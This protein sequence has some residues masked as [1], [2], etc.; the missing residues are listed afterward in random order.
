MRR[1]AVQFGL[2]LALAVLFVVFSFLERDCDPLML[3][4]SHVPQRPVHFWIAGALSFKFHDVKR[5]LLAPV[6][7][8]Y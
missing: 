7:V 5:F 2:R 8:C 3:T 4:S 6:L 1:T